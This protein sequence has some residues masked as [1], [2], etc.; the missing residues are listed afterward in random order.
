MLQ[1]LLEEAEQID[2]KVGQIRGLVPLGPIKKGV[3]DRDALAS[4][5]E[6]RLKE[7]IKPEELERETAILVRMGL[8]EPGF[9]YGAFLLALLTEQIAGF[10]DHKTRELVIIDADSD[11]STQ[12]VVM[13]HELFHAIQDQHFTIESL[14]PPGRGLV[15]TAATKTAP[16]PD[17]RSSRATPPP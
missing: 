13:A 2:D 10:Y 3:K 17:R 8:L 16:W 12:R 14:Q 4:M 7:E 9:D 1:R 11:M 6:A 15:G 5:L